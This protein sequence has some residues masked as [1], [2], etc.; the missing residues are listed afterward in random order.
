MTHSL[1]A[2]RIE[3][4]CAIV[5]AVA[6][7]AEHTTDLLHDVSPVLVREHEREVQPRALFPGLGPATLGAELIKRILFESWLDTDSC[8]PRLHAWEGNFIY[9]GILVGSLAGW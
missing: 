3:R 4:P 5:G 2:E 6:G 7:L 9:G 1:E 8:T